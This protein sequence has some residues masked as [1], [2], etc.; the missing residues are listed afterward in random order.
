MTS[1][2]SGSPIIGLRLVITGPTTVNGLPLLPTPLTETTTGPAPVGVPAGTVVPM[3]VLLQLLG[4]AVVPL[5]VTV[6]LPCVAPKLD[7]EI[8]TWVPMAP[9]FGESSVMLGD[10]LGD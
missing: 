7:P 1:V 6:L 9:E 4:V 8:V 3:L 10:G 5:N 2:D